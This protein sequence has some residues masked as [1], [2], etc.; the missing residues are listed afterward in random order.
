ML[1]S[2]FNLNLEANITVHQGEQM[3]R[4]TTYIEIENTSEDDITINIILNLLNSSQNGKFYHSKFA[5]LFHK[6]KCD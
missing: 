6:V 4:V 3:D 1:Y 2:I 5:S